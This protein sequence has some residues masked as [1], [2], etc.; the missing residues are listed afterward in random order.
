MK[1][2]LLSLL[3]VFIGFAAN[4]QL[5]VTTTETPEQLILN[6]FL[7]QN[8]SISNVKFN[9]SAANA[10]LLRDQVGRYSNGNNG[11]MSLGSAQGLILCTGKAIVAAGANTVQGATNATTTPTIGD[12]DLALITNASVHNVCI[13]EFDFVPVGNTILFDY[14]FASEEYNTFVNSSFND[15]FGLFL[16]GPGISGPYSNNSANIATIPGTSLA[17]SINN[18]NNGTNNAGPCENCAYYVNNPVGQGEYQFNGRTTQLTASAPVTTGQTYHLKFAIANIGDNAYDSG[19]FLTAGSF[20][21][22]MLGNDDFTT[23]NV[24]LYPNPAA[25]FLHVSAKEAISR[26]VIYDTLG[27]ALMNIPATG[28]EIQ[29]ATQDLSSG[30]Y[31]VELTLENNKKITQ[32]LLVR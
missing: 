13:I 28:T 25:G 8:T 14:I 27:R 11:A 6:T 4:A 22:A 2:P 18:L 12:P 5:A 32:K 21:A 24:T 9:G 31:I 20:R 23:E 17:V 10:Q 26:V 19:I 29:L 15:V 1:K 30:T 3:F 7:G 16:S